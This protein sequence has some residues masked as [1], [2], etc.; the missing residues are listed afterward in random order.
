MPCGEAGGLVENGLFGFGV[1]YE[2]K[3]ISK[4][5]VGGRL[6][7]RCFFYLYPWIWIFLGVGLGYH[8]SNNYIYSD[9]LDYDYSFSGGARDNAFY[10]AYKSGITITPETG[11]KLDIGEDGGFYLNLGFSV[12][13]ITGKDIPDAAYF[14][15]A[16]YSLT[17]TKGASDDEALSKSSLESGLFSLSVGYGF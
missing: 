9:P 7:N 11:L 15:D 10:T 6:W 13:L 17:K 5:S 4:I 14:Y 3:L 8:H 16:D 12:S 2:R 1:R